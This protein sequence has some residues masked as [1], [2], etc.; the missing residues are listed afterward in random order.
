MVLP[1]LAPMIAK[2]EGAPTNCLKRE[3]DQTQNFSG[4]GYICR[5]RTNGTFSWDPLS[6]SNNNGSGSNNQNQQPNAQD[7]NQLPPGPK[8]TS[9]TPLSVF[10]IDSKV[11]KFQP[12]GNINP[13]GHITPSTHGGV[14]VPTTPGQGTKNNAINGQIP[15]S[16]DVRLPVA[17]NH[18]L[19][20]QVTKVVFSDGTT[21]DDY[22]LS[23]N[24][25]A[26]IYI[27]LGHITNPPSKLIAAMKSQVP[28]PVCQ[29]SSNVD[30]RAKISSKI[31]LCFYPN[32]SF[33]AVAGSI[34]GKSGPAIGVD[35][36]A[37][38][39][40]K[41][42][43]L[44]S[45]GIYPNNGESTYAIC[46]LDLYPAALRSTINAPMGCG[47]AA[48]D[49]TGTAAG[50][51]FEPGNAQAYNQQKVISLVP[52]SLFRGQF[53]LAT[54]S[55]V[56]SVLHANSVYLIETDPAK[57]LTG[58]LIC[59]KAKPAQNVTPGQV[60]SVG[61]RVVEKGSREQLILSDCQGFGSVTLERTT[62]LGP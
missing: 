54:G 52:L 17:I 42:L 9:L 51:W 13:P 35:F 55:S 38:D 20:V 14:Q 46:A 33:T 62:H 21:L 59:I 18:A 28:N 19:N 47:S 37:W 8:C 57:I 31:T 60:I 12:L 6:N 53:A 7:P 41:P 50:S 3:V 40:T 10:P 56:P 2:A 24:V 4:K 5:G 22:A 27:S 23:Y 16:L 36:G 15:V 44:A 45:F 61:V 29:N 39:L 48:L 58:S 26:K 30:A 25:C 11:T 43:K 34:I 49:K 32:I 1:L